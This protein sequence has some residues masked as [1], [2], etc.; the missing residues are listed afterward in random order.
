MVGSEDPRDTPYLISVEQF[1]PAEG[2][3]TVTCDFRFTGVRSADSNSFSILTRSAEQR[4]IAE[5]PWSGTLASCARC[6]FSSESNS[7]G[8]ILQAGVKLESDRELTSISW[9]GFEPPVAG[10]AYRVV[11]RD[12]GVNVSFTVL[13]RDKPSTSKTVTCR[14]LFRGKANFVALEGSGHGTTLIEHVKISQNISDTP[15][16]S[17]AD[18]SSHLQNDHNLHEAELQLLSTLAPDD[19]TLVL[20]DDFAADQ[21]VANDWSCL[22]DVLVRDGAV[23][24][25]QPNAEGHIDTWKARPY[26]LTRKP[27]D[28]REGE[29]TI[30][31]RI[32]F[33]ENFLAGYG[34]SFSVMTRADD[35]R[36][37]GPGWENT[38]LQRGVRANFWPAAW[39]SKHNLEIHE[40]PTSNSITLLATQ[41]LQTNPNV[42]S[43]LFRVVDDGQS[44][45][46][47]I[48]DPRKPEALQTISSP[49]TSAVNQGFIGFESCWGSPVTLDDVR[50]YQNSIPETNS[51]LPAALLTN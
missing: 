33:A 17:Y 13:L 42:H 51:P 25:G 2:P 14:S 31:G 27:L 49:A 48:V 4:G 21:L 34:A 23:Q 43:Y 47:T 39:D 41:G 26:L 15:L 38:V 11:M 44:V 20:Q 12:D 37:T 24:L 18:F 16:L 40:K 29:L 32:T 35:N 8:G 6:S 1:D 7:S 30:L 3:I 50:I 22:G 28:P 36:G 46:L 10:T 5:V 45:T 19:A 9:S